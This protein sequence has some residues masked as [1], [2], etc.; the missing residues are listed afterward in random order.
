MHEVAHPPLAPA[1][2]S[3]RTGHDSCLLIRRQE[4][5]SISQGPDEWLRRRSSETKGSP[6]LGNRPTRRP[7][8]NGARRNHCICALYRRSRERSAWFP[9]A[10]RSLLKVDAAPCSRAEG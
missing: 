10:S 7:V 1:Q 8:R 6:P 9:L 5:S 3:T 4:T 2:Q